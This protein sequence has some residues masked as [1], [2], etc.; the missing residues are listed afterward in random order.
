[1]RQY[2]VP[3]GNGQVLASGAKSETHKAAVQ[4]NRVENHATLHLRQLVEIDSAHLHAAVQFRGY[5]CAIPAHGCVQATAYYCRLTELNYSA[6]AV[7]QN[8]VQQS[9]H[10]STEFPYNKKPP[11]QDSGY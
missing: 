9:D 3:V 10:P 5:S 1:M 2:S 4:W 7:L 11:R 6:A 8:P